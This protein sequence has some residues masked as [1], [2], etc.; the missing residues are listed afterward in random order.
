MKLK[1]N[2]TDDVLTIEFSQDK[3]DDAFEGKDML[4]QTNS[5]KEPVL[6]EIFKATHFLSRAAKTLPKEVQRQMY[7]ALI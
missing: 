4:I 5:E 1:Y 7:Q 6:V 3:I 2:K